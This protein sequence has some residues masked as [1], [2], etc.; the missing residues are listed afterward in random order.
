[1]KKGILLILLPFI[2]AGCGGNIA[3]PA[4]SYHLIVEDDISEDT[5]YME[6]IAL[7]GTNFPDDEF[8]RF[9]QDEKDTNGNDSLDED[10]LEGCSYIFPSDEY[11]IRD[12]TGIELIPT[13]RHISFIGSGYFELTEKGHK[14]IN[15]ENYHLDCLDLSNN[16]EIVD[17][18]MENVVIDKDSK[19]A[20]NDTLKKLEIVESDIKD[21]DLSNYSSLRVLMLQ[22]DYF[23]K[24][25]DLS[26]LTELEDLSLNGDIKIKDI[27]LS[28]LNNLETLD[29]TGV[30]TKILNLE[31]NPKLI[32]VNCSGGDKALTGKD[33]GNISEI[34]FPNDCKIENLNCSSNDIEVLNIRS[35]PC[36]EVLDCSNNKIG[37]LD[38]SDSPNIFAVTCTNNDIQ[39]LNITD[40]VIANN[41]IKGGRL[42]LWADD[43]ITVAIGAELYAYPDDLME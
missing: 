15:E 26:K 6:G 25:I 39:A 21:I 10:E 31:N 32:N 18:K 24:N 13:V 1:M 4:D 3:T 11:C 23:L 42:S 30:D 16:N 29:I 20:I 35:L 40:T 37:I 2:L 38:F 36:L 9:L 14:Y 41:F 27:D 34:I 8:R 43:G 28:M 5:S 17:L 33:K 12:F 19:V 7:S 22:S